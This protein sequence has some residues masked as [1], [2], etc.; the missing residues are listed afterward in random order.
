MELKEKNERKQYS[1][2]EII[3]EMDLETRA[4]SSIGPLGEPDPLKI[5]GL[6]P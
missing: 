1:K 3:H 4:G 5:P 6:E 2:P